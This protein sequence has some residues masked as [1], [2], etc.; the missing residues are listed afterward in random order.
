[1]MDIVCLCMMDKIRLNSWNGA[2]GYTMNYTTVCMDS[3]WVSHYEYLWAMAWDG[4]NVETP[5]SS[6]DIHSIEWPLPDEF[7]INSTFGDGFWL[8]FPFGPHD[9]FFKSRCWLHLLMLALM[10]E[11]YLVGQYILKISWN[12]HRT[13]L[14][15]L[16]FMGQKAVVS[17]GIRPQKLLWVD[18]G[19]FFCW[20]GLNILQVL[21]S[22]LS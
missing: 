22:M 7:S 20:G 9:F 14:V 4:F 11:N 16:S 12:H 1:M 6:W 8:L 5:T 13:E 2:I 18:W 10:W 17:P 3:T 21:S 15:I 19:C